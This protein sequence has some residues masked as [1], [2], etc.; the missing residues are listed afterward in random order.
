MFTIFPSKISVPTATSSAIIYIPLFQSMFEISQHLCSQR[1][2]LIYIQNILTLCTQKTFRGQQLFYSCMEITFLFC[3]YCTFLACGRISTSWIIPLFFSPSLLQDCPYQTVPSKHPV[4]YPY[5]PA[6]YTQT[7][8]SSRPRHTDTNRI[9][10]IMSIPVCS[11]RDKSLIEPV[12]P[13]S[14]P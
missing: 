7:D 4:P 2:W 9:V 13:H 6:H 11:P 5:L 14:I 1:C 12:R 10:I 8:L 3:T